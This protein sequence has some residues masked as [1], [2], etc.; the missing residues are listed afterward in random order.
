MHILLFGGSFDPPHLGHLIVIQQAFELIPDIDELWLLPAFK[1]TFQKKLAYYPHRINMTKTLIMQLPHKVQQKI[2]L[3]TIECDNRLKGETYQTLALLKKKHPDYTFSF[4]MGTD[5]LPHFDKWGYYKELLEM[6]HF[7]VYPRAGYKNDLKY[8]N[9]T[10]LKS[11]SQVITNIS[12][13]LIRDRLAKNF[14]VNHLLPIAI[15]NY[16]ATESVYT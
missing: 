8:S 9:M 2:K 1:H 5:Q 13:T 6:M 16:I 4:L 14:P 3:N 10:L 12:S 15:I 11:D 7:Y